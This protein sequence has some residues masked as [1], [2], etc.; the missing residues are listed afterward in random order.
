MFKARGRQLD[1]FTKE[2][3]RRVSEISGPA[4]TMKLVRSIM[5][6]STRKHNVF[7]PTTLISSFE[8]VDL[9]LALSFF[10][11]SESKTHIRYDLFSCSKVSEHEVQQLSRMLQTSI[12][13]LVGDMKV[14]YLSISNKQGWVM[15]T[16][17]RSLS[18]S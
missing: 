2:L 16:T 10:P 4:F 18:F 15:D 3:D 1:A 13:E 9:S 6:K 8:N 5:R 11:A 7:F 17:L 14:E 12:E